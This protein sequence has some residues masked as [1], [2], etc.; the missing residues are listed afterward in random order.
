[1]IPA[2]LNPSPG[3][4]AAGQMAYAGVLAAWQDY[5]AN[6]N[7]GR[8]VILIGHS[9]GSFHLKQL[10]REQLDANPTLR[11]Q[12]VSALL[13]GGDVTV[14]SGSDAGGAFQNVPACRSSKETGCVVAYSSFD[15]TPPADSLFGRPHGTAT[16][17]QVLCVNPVS[18]K[19]GTKPLAVEPYFQ[20]T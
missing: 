16:D 11:K 3:T 15:T 14:K 1:T 6:D 13:L 17:L 18:P 8:G 19:A 10:I 4:A 20:T 5:L 7:D 9:Q 2:I 12:L